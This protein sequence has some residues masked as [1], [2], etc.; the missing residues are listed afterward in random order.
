[1][2]A[3]DFS[4]AATWFDPAETPTITTPFI[5]GYALHDALLKPLPG[6]AMAPALAE[7]GAES[8]DSQSY[9]FKLREGLTFHN[10]AP[11]IAEDVKF[12]F[13]RDK[14]PAT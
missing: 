6:N 12:S 3:L 5:F 10:S 4:I 11:F 14:W 13:E 2:F 7:S 8:T 9:E 1:V